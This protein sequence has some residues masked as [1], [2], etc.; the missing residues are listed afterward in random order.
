MIHIERFEFDRFIR[1]LTSGNYRGEE[2]TV[3]LD[4]SAR[5]HG[6]LDD[7]HTF[8]EAA[9]GNR[10]LDKVYLSM[11]S[12]LDPFVVQRLDTLTFAL[13]SLPSLT[14]L[15]IAEISR[16]AFLPLRQILSNTTHINKLKV[17]LFVGRI[18]SHWGEDF[19]NSIRH[20]ETLKAIEVCVPLQDVSTFCRALMTMPNLQEVLLYRHDLSDQPG[21]LEAFCGLLE[22]CPSLQFI[23]VFLRGVSD[24]GWGKIVQ[25]VTDNPARPRLRVLSDQI[26]S[27]QAFE[28]AYEILCRDYN[29]E[30]LAL[31]MKF[32]QKRLWDT[33]LKL[34]AAGRRYLKEHATSRTKGVEVL[35]HLNENSGSEKAALDCIYYHLREDNP[36]LC[37]LSPLTNN[38]CN[39]ADCLEETNL[40]PCDDPF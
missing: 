20:S 19:N 31:P 22:R 2:D 8:I 6:M 32:R 24:D 7:V 23:S 17:L 40:K 25:A 3:Y 38:K 39:R 26:M 16:G 10:L 5:L 18:P 29:V 27:D 9:R 14:E 15:H 13:E 30:H 37:I 36:S 21:S 35:I 1:E 4:S 12:I 34:N 28:T 33:I 11:H